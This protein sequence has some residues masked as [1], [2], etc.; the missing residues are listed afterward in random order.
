M[1]VK[2]DLCHFS[3]YKIYPGHGQKFVGKDAK[4][5]FFLNQKVEKLWHQKIKAAKLTW[6]QAWRRMN[7][8]GAVAGGARRM[9]KKAQKFQKAIVGLSLD[10]MKAKRGQRKQFREAAA[11]KGV[12]D[13]KARQAKGP[14]VKAPKQ[15]ATKNVAGAGAGKVKNFKK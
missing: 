15:K 5:T 7:K 10:D 3:E 13:A 4:I 12:K 9:K 2:T 8:K 11:A 6:T 1:V 14:K